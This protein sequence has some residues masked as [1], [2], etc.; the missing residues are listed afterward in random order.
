VIKR[1]DGTEGRDLSVVTHVA[2]F[3][4]ALSRFGQ[5][6]GILIQPFVGGLEYSVNVVSGPRGHRVF[7]PVCKGSSSL[8]GTHP[9]RRLR[10]C[11]C[12]VLTEGMRHRL[13]QASLDL[14]AAIGSQGL[15]EIELIA[16][17]DALWF[18]E[19]NPRLSATMRMASIACDRS[20]FAE[21]ALSRIAASWEG[22]VASAVRFTAELPIAPG[23]DVAVLHNLSASMPLWLSSRV[24]TAADR[25]EVLRGRLVEVATALGLPGPL[26]VPEHAVWP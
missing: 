20:I 15:L 24:T 18:L 25:A 21:L 26:A 10:H 23:T 3:D 7:E 4:A 5:L 1:N 22:G 2:D 8:A 12:S 6:E 9:C 13:V 16:A 11:P 19:L 17:G 14:A